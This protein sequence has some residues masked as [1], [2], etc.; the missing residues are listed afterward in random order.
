MESGVGGRLI[1]CSELEVIMVQCTRICIGGSEVNNKAT[2]VIV[3][4]LWAEI[5]NM[6]QKCCLLRLFL[7]IV[8]VFKLIEH[9]S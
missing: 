3:A 1:E 5:S 2:Q 8:L 9:V 4:G 7:E 6:K